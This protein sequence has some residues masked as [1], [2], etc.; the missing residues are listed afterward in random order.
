MQISKRDAQRIGN[1]LGSPVTAGRKK[2][3]HQRFKIC[4]D[5][6]IWAT[7]GVSHGKHNSN[8][9]VLSQLGVSYTEAQ[10]LA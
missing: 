3:R 8:L 4:V 7:F 1:K 10:K 2:Q 9:H 5:G 6:K